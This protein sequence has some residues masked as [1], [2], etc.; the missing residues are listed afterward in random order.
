MS[1]SSEEETAHYK[2]KE[3]DKRKNARRNRD[4]KKEDDK[5][6]KERRKMKMKGIPFEYAPKLSKD[7]HVVGE[8]ID[9]HDEGIIT[10]AIP[11]MIEN[12]RKPI[13]VVEERIF[14]TSDWHVPFHDELL[15]VRLLEAA[16]ELDVRTL[17]IGGDFWDCDN[18]SRFTH[19]APVVSFKQE[20]E[21]IKA[22]LDVLWRHFDKVY[23]C[24]GNHEKRYI[25]MNA[26]KMNLFDMYDLAIP[27]S[28]SKDK[29]RETFHI[30]M[31]DHMFF[32]SGERRWM[33]S[34]PRNFRVTNLSVAKDLAAK[35]QC[36][37]FVAHGHQMAQGYD[38][39]GQYQL[40]DG[41]GLFNPDA[42][43]YLRETT[44]YAAVKT[45]FYLLDAG[46]IRVFNGR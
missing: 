13:D 36:N 14:L 16:E 25:D 32:E 38:R 9:M 34:H 35:F 27:D 39:S 30:T 46:H 17:A 20:V 5:L 22:V 43:D 42:L 40:V 8:I 24:R 31:D 4:K 18:F 29:F 45:G 15:L 19:L 12:I 1:Y 26:G 28:M 10:H 6:Y 44:A 2:Q 21:H 23:I 33:M 11:R 41:G 3:I 7:N 37:Q